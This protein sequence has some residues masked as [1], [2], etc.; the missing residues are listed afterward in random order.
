MKYFIIGLFLTI[1]A[2]GN[3]QPLRDINFNYLYDPDQPAALNLSA[4]RTPQGFTAHYELQWQDSTH[5]HSIQWQLRTGFGEKDG[6]P[7]TGQ[8]ETKQKNSI[9]GSVQVA[10]AASAQILTAKVVD[11]LAKRAWIYFI[12]L[13]PAYPVNATLSANGR[14]L[15]QPFITRYD[16][17]VYKGPAASAVVTYYNDF[18]P[19]ASPPFSESQAR[20]TK[21]IKSD[22]LFTLSSLQ[23]VRFSKTGLYLVQ[24]DTTSTDALAF[25]VEDDYPRFS[26]VQSLAEPLVYICTKQEFD[27]VQA[28]NG[29]KKAFDRVILGITGDTERARNLMRSYFRRVELANQYFTSYKEGWKTD[30]G[31]VY[32]IFGVPDEVFCFA[33]R[34]V[35]N[36]KKASYKVAFN[37]AKSATVFDPDNFVLIRQKKYQD[38]WYEVID[39]WRNARF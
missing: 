24:T 39:L 37:F 32:I 21:K 31:M 4:V 9:L 8:V 36:Y 34:E 2:A 38:T 5:A 12:V 23:P 1:G 10:A 17:V 20:V 33:D 26:R 27:K 6:A 15:V 13:D 29:D 16:D 19:S 28:S 25:R 14:E 18:F 22:S 35:W 30:R 7:L 11:E 3:A